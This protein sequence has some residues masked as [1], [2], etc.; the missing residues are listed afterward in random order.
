MSIVAIPAW[1][2]LGLLPPVD[3]ASPPTGKAR[4]PYPVSLKDVVM[5]FATSP[6]REGVMDGLLRYRAALH[7]FG[8]D[9]GFQW[10]DGS[11]TEDVETL[12]QRAP[13]DIDVVSFVRAPAGLRPDP[14]MLQVLD[15]DAAKKSFKVD[16]YFVEMNRLPPEQL[17][18]MSAYWY[19]LWAHRR[20]HVWKGFLQIDLAPSEDADA[21]AWLNQH[22]STGVGQ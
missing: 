5:T 1:N 20:N 2:S 19:S 11:F 12:E 10:L 3:P 8:L 18:A 16:A 17:T 22:R 9:S 4:S 7:A 6:E 13:N 15:H 21:L 14:A